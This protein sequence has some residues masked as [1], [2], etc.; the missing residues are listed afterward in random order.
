MVLDCVGVGVGSSAGKF[1]RPNAL[2]DVFSPSLYRPFPGA[3]EIVVELSEHQVPKRLCLCFGLLAPGP[4]VISSVRSLDIDL[5]MPSTRLLVLPD[6]ASPSV[7]GG[8]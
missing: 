1:F 4:S 2:L 8:S 5:I 3:S 6:V 7:P